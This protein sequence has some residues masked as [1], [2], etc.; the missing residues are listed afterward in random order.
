MIREKKKKK[1]TDAGAPPVSAGGVAPSEVAPK[2]TQTV[3]LAPGNKAKKVEP[4]QVPDDTK[5]FDSTTV[6]QADPEVFAKGKTVKGVVTYVPDGDGA[7]LRVDGNK[8]VSLRLAHIDSPET[9]K[10]KYNKSGQPYAKEA[11][12][13]LE[14]LIKNKEISLNIV[15]G[16]SEKNKFRPVVQIEVEGKNVNLEMVAAGAAWLHKKYGVP[17]EYRNAHAE[18][19]LNRRGIFA[20]TDALHPGQ[21]RA[22]DLGLIETDE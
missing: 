12:E 3:Y 11:K 8:T 1:L 21:H 4:L 14:K 10:K 6:S 2:Q 22:T 20:N 13:Y 7:Y 5:W 18:A 9:E 17:N 19:Q 16:A 15:E